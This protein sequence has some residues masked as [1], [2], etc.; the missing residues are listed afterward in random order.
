MALGDFDDL[1]DVHEPEMVRSGGGF[2]DF[3]ANLMGQAEARA[4]NAFLIAD[5]VGEECTKAEKLYL[6]GDLAGAMAQWESVQTFVGMNPLVENAR[7]SHAN[8]QRVMEEMDRG[9][10]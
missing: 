8:A 5:V 4:E 6:S 1:G 7:V 9:S 3:V 2:R 10:L